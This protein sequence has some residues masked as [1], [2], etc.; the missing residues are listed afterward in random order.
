MTAGAA[1]NTQ[2]GA[3]V[4]LLGLVIFLNYVDRGAI[5]VAA[6]LMKTE[7]GLSAFAF[8]LAVSAFSWVYSPLQLVV[9]YLCDRYSVY[10]LLAWGVVIWAGATLLTGFAGGL[11]SLIVL[12]GI[13]GIGE[14][15]G[16]PASSKIIAE[17]LPA[18]RRGMANAIVSVGLAL[19]PALG[20]LAGGLLLISHGWR[21]IF[22]TFGLVTLLWLLP[23][24]LVSR[25]FHARSSGAA[26]PQVPVR[27][28]VGR[29]PLWSMSIAHFAS[30]YGFYFIL[31]WLPLYLVQS[32]GLS[33]GQMTLLAT[34]AYGAQAVA[35]LAFGAISD[36]WT[37]SGRSEGTVRRWM[38]I[39]AQ[40]VQ[41][42]AILGILGADSK[43]QLGF[44]LAI[45]GIATGA[46]SLNIFAVAQMFAGPRATG[47][48][49]GIQNAVGN[50]SGILGPIITGAII[51]LAGYDYA[52]ILAA[53][54]AALGGIWWAIGVPKIEQVG[55]G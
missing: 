17:Q 39:I 31:A 6:P 47:T 4:L 16:F 45:A 49:C 1:R 5:G 30:N 37:K 18:E 3:L 22:I 46:L 7:L 26:R 50:T 44:L 13:L 12:R 40:I 25:G 33:L 24:H 41:A 51:D 14:S 53:A 10:R 21:A 35:A 9:G 2:A 23:W 20:T 15:F 32:R 19:G 55:T 36:R 43:L 8:G 42:A 38:M 29:W 11:F 52:F 54:V 48:W 27:A 34:L 28:L